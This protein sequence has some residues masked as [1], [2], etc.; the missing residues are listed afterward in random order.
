MLVW[1]ADSAS[2]ASCISYCMSAIAFVKIRIKEPNIK[3]SYEIRNCEFI[4]F[5]AIVLSE[6]LCAMYLILR[7][8]CTLTVQELVIIGG[9]VVR[10]VMFA[11]I[12]KSKY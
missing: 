5:M 12:C 9:W 3:K 4:G 1:I 2:F 10:G 7:M 8:G 11:A 6:F